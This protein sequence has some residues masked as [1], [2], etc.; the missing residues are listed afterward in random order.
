MRIESLPNDHLWWR[1]ASFRWADPLDP[2]FAQRY[3][4]RWNPPESFQTLYLN[5]DQVTA[6]LNLRYFIADWPYE[7]EDLRSDTGPVLVAAT[8]PTRQKVADAHT[9]QGVA[10]LSLPPTYPVDAT[11][12]IV[13]HAVC[14]PIGWRARSAGLRGILCRSAQSPDGAGRELAWFPARRSRATQVD[15]LPFE[16]WY[17]G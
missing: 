11:G 8:L 13:P 15:V 14:Q 12:E 4:G 2:T 7:P 10:A 17:W 3:G 6:R 9:P 16:D 1:I 5:Q